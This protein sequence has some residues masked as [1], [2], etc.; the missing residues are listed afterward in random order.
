MLAEEMKRKE[1]ELRKR[2]AE[3]CQKK[4]EEEEYKRYHEEK[5][6]EERK[7]LEEREATKAYDQAARQ[8]LH[9]YCNAVLAKL[10]QEEKKLSYFE[11]RKAASTVREAITWANF[12]PTL[13]AK[14]Y[15]V[16]QTS[17]EKVVAPLVDEMNR[18]EGFAY[19]KICSDS[20]YEIEMDFPER[21]SVTDQLPQL[22]EEFLEE[23]L[24]MP[25][26]YLA[27]ASP[28]PVPGAPPPISDRSDLL[29][30]I[31]AGGA[32]RKNLP[33]AKDSD[34]KGGYR[35]V[36]SAR[37]GGGGGG[38]GSGAKQASSRFGGRGE[39]GR[40]RGAPSVEPQSSIASILGAR[41]RD[42]ESSESDEEES[43][44]ASG[45]ASD[46]D[47]QATLGTFGDMEKADTLSFSS[48]SENYSRDSWGDDLMAE[49]EPKQEGEGSTSIKKGKMEK[50]GRNGRKGRKGR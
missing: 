45:S 1:G 48:I 23:T 47:V 12:N 32:L 42:N 21:E 29:S 28:P 20:A 38:G 25:I 7:L 41:R 33:D 50:K 40:G 44:R 27:M 43:F 36:D 22:D 14:D 18:E 37:G 46:E 35:G 15:L 39:R 26:A 4:L 24:E 8:S 49:C 13:L 16:R 10:A 19:S 30:G 17:V 9:D 31:R 3:D 2:E 5:E 34:R 6:G 11:K